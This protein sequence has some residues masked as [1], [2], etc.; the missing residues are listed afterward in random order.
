MVNFFAGSQRI[1]RIALE[2]ISDFDELFAIEGLS[3]LKRVLN[4]LEQDTAQTPNI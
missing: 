3:V 4:Q 1:T 2:R